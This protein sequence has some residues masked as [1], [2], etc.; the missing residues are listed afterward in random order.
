M[1]IDCL[2]TWLA[3]LLI[4]TSSACTDGKVSFGEADAGTADA[5]L[6]EGG[7]VPDGAPAE[8]APPPP[9]HDAGDAG[10]DSAA[11]Q[12]AAVDGSQEDDGPPRDGAAG[13]AGPHASGLPWRSGVSPGTGDGAQA[14]TNTAGFAAW[15]GRPVDVAAVFIGKNSWQ[16]SYAAYLTNEVLGANGAVAR[17]IDHGI[18]PVL[19]VPL[20]T[21]ADAG[22][23]AFVAAGTID[24][25]HQ[26][27][28]DK[29]HGVV[30]SHRIY[31][32]LGHEA[33][34][35]Y[36]WSYVNHDGAG[37]PDPAVPADY[38][39]AWRRI[40]SIYRATIPGAR[41]VWNRLKS[42]HDQ[43]ITAY[44]P[45]D[46]VVDIISVDVYDNGSGGY[47]DAATAPGW[48]N[49]CYGSYNASTGMAKGL[50]GTLDFAQSRGKKM[51][52]DEWGA[53]NDDLA[54]ANGANNGFF[55]GG[56]WDFLVA[57]S[58]AVEYESYFNRAGGGRHQIWPKTSYNPLPS[59]AYLAHW[60]P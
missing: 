20:V 29:I 16:V 9:A 41:M 28:A 57:N 32:R 8:D 22:K 1:R 44:Y 18:D 31:L 52:I 27:V 19:T 53:T 54:P 15:R 34:E 23:F 26:A 38:K 10:R 40:A 30:G 33:D 4:A 12:D 42:G 2:P 17:L 55:A 39:A 35:G 6:H 43:P 13:D 48:L 7:T 60:H 14:I 56:V 49:L 45:G 51:A 11:G 37:Q 47:C 21:L 59:D 25:Q 5:A 36:P 50:K 3:A 58:A 46:D 24:A